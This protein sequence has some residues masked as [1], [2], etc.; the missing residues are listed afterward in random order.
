MLTTLGSPC[1]SD[2]H[3]CGWNEP[4]TRVGR[5]TSSVRSGWHWVFIRWKTIETKTRGTHSPLAPCKLA[6]LPAALKCHGE[7][8]TECMS[9]IEIAVT[10]GAVRHL[11]CQHPCFLLDALVDAVAS[12]RNTMLQ[13]QPGCFRVNPVP[14]SNR[15]MWFQT[16]IYE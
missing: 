5:S 1:F 9:T 2:T 7:P 15:P 16:I 13:P 12:L 14:G 11:D 4:D 8:N 3:Q 10:Q 6:N